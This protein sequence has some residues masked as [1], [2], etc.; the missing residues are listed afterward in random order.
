GSAAAQSPSS[1]KPLTEAQVRSFFDGMETQM[2]QWVNAGSADKLSGWLDKH[3][4]DGA[5]FL[6]DT[7][8]TVEERRVASSQGTLGKDGLM[9]ATSMLMG[10][11]SPHGRIRDY[12]LDMTVNG[13]KLLSGGALAIV[14]A[15]SRET[16][17][18]PRAKDSGAGSAGDQGAGSAGDQK[19][20]Q[21]T[22]AGQC[23]YF[24]V[25]G[26]GD[27]VQL[28]TAICQVDIQL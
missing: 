9:K 12:K 6:Y 18:I 24:L 22:A 11:G 16:G 28:A 7:T 1:Q 2:T 3:T 19:D 8:T 26:G 21:L 10:A 5:Q 27:T 17:T 20:M 25:P 14:D 15:D 4:L 13:V 23:R